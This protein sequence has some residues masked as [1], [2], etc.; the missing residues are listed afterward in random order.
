MKIV[1]R[2]QAAGV[3]TL[4]VSE[5]FR[6]LKS[7]HCMIDGWHSDDSAAAQRHWADFLELISR[8]MSHGMFG[9]PWTRAARDAGFLR[10]RSVD[11]FKKALS[12]GESAFNDAWRLSVDLLSGHRGGGVA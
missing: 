3:P 11:N 9:W 4:D 7:G 2:L 6:R 8:L 12:T 10:E 5:F 1:R